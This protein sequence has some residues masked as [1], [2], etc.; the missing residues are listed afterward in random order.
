M[1]CGL[2]HWKWER[3]T[4]EWTSAGPRGGDPPT[5]SMGDNGKRA[6]GKRP[7]TPEANPLAEAARSAEKRR[8]TEAAR[9]AYSNPGEKQSTSIPRLMEPSVRT[10]RSGKKIPVM[11]AE[12]I[13]H[14]DVF[15]VRDG[16]LAEK[17]LDLARQLKNHV[18][19][20]EDGDGSEMEDGDEID[21]PTASIAHAVESFKRQLQDEH[22]STPSTVA[23]LG[24]NGEGK[25][26]L[27][28]L[29]L[30]VTEV[31]EEEYALNRRAA[32]GAPKDANE[33]R[34]RK[35][36]LDSLEGSMELRKCYSMTEV[37]VNKNTGEI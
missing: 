33:A 21:A 20:E 2:F 26:F 12:E 7:A 19:G 28:N 24:R 14:E 35:H 11:T 6:M 29:L 27:I 37:D 3:I 8:K 13:E 10:T 22:T 36:L 4:S 18:V 30:Q 5:A 23:F 16:S 25:S 1:R 31:R 17:T 32:A 15:Q 9:L 34:L